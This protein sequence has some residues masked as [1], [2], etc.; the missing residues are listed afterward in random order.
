MLDTEKVEARKVCLLIKND[1]YRNFQKQGCE[2]VLN[3]DH[4]ILSLYSP[5][6]QKGSGSCSDTRA[7]FFCQQKQQQSTKIVAVSPFYHSL[8]QPDQSSMVNVLLCCAQPAARNLLTMFHETVVCGCL[9]HIYLFG[10]LYASCNANLHSDRDFFLTKIDN[11]K[12][13]IIGQELSE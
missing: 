5:T 9:E 6:F 13:V 10:D 1:L 8:C 12:L 2:K 4:H 7:C 11:Q 3:P